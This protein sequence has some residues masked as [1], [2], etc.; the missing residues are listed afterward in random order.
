VVLVV[1]IIGR[2]VCHGMA[3]LSCFINLD[4]LSKNTNIK[5]MSE[6]QKIAVAILD[7][8]KSKKVPCEPAEVIQNL[9][10]KHDPWQVREVIWDLT[11]NATAQ[12]TWDRKL[13]LGPNRNPQKAIAA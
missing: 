12:L 4:V 2:K 9:A 6:T 3:P 13:K 11:A 10:D 5:C 1:K 8:L 7:F